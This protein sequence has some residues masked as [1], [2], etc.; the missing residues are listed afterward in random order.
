MNTTFSHTPSQRSTCV[1]LKIL[2]LLMLNREQLQQMAAALSRL[3]SEL[4]LDASTPN[5]LPEDVRSDLYATVSTAMRAFKPQDTQPMLE[6]LVPCAWAEFAT[7]EDP[8]SKAAAQ[9]TGA[10]KVATGGSVAGTEAKASGT[11]LSPS[12]F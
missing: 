12:L 2:Q 5:R 3:L 9:T 10:L 8:S 7:P 11:G 1:G 4:L 6:T